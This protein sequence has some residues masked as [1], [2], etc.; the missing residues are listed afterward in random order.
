MGTILSTDSLELN[1]RSG[2]VGLDPPLSLAF[3]PLRHPP[4]GEGNPY[5]DAPTCK[6]RIPGRLALLPHPAKS[7]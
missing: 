7:L 6:N 3:A 4:N 5:D 1:L 2:E